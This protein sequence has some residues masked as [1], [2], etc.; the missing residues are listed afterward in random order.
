MINT[1][2]IQLKVLSTFPLKFKGFL[3]QK[4]KIQNDKLGETLIM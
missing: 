3:G 4:L 2:G 1:G